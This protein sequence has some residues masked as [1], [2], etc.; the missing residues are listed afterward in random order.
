MDPSKPPSLSIYFLPPHV[1]T[2]IRDIFFWV[3]QGLALKVVLIIGYIPSSD[4][5]SEKRFI[6]AI[7]NWLICLEMYARTHARTH[8]R[9][10]KQTNKQTNQRM[11]T[12]TNTRSNTNTH[13][14]THA[15]TYT[16]TDIHT[17]SLFLTH[18]HNQIISLVL[19]RSLSLTIIHEFTH[20]P[21]HPPTH[22]LTHQPTHPLTC[23]LPPTPLPPPF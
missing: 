14:H 10:N 15:R 5:Y 23:Y 1:S 13:I 20:P 9:T 17:H 3:P 16:Y 11:H 18:T 12:H 19:C 8:A 22:P 6:N 7:E 21:T 2:M 4:T